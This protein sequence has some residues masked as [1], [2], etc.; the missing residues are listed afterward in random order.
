MH[1]SVECLGLFV[2][3]PGLLR[4]F[5]QVATWYD[6]SNVFCSVTDDG[7]GNPPEVR[8]RIFELGFKAQESDFMQCTFEHKLDVLSMMDVLEHMPYPGLALGKAAEIIRSG[9][10]LVISLPDLS[11]SSWRMMDAAKS[12]PYWMEIEHH[13]NFSR[14]R[15]IALLGERGFEVADF[16]I[17]YSIKHRWSFMLYGKFLLYG[18]YWD[19][20]FIS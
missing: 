6:S 15:L 13:H 18:F 17:P 19:D 14:E 8:R 1:L 4:W 2:S 5:R 10:V 16:G 11:C 20:V 9:G 3:K 12:N 7:T